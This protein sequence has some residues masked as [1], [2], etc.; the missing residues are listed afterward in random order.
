MQGGVWVAAEQEASVAGRLVATFA[1][2]SSSLS[3]GKAS[4]DKAS[5]DKVFGQELGSDHR[6]T[7][8]AQ[9]PKRILL[10]EDTRATR[11]VLVSLLERHG[12][13]VVA[14]KDGLQAVQI[15]ERE[16]RAHRRFDV[17]ILDLEMPVMDGR[18]AARE[19]RKRT[20]SR[21]IRLIALTAHR[22]EGNPDLL[23]SADF[24]VAVGKPVDAERLF[25]AIAP[26][27]VS[28]P[29]PPETPRE[30]NGDCAVDYAGALA[31]LCGNEQLLDDLVQFFL[32]DSPELLAEARA[33]IGRRDAKALERTAH[34]IR[35]LASNFGAQPTV[36]AA[37]VLEELG[38]DAALDDAESA[39]QDLE[40]EVRRLAAILEQRAGSSASRGDVP[41]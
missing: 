33:A 39:Y 8:D 20:A 10:A 9:G 12:H 7:S 28:S 38:H 32:N 40:T 26:R 27:R 24:D 11:Q 2:P 3:F 16:A 19:I 41:R 15:L 17:A 5:F 36:N 18:E 37:A 35:G 1:L 4:F 13:T 23:G 25:E 31:R 30:T 29:P 22:T 14:A 34:G 6:P 21:P